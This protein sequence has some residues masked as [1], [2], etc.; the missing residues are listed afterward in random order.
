M[1]ERL[2]LLLLILGL[3]FVT[4]LS[5]G[6]AERHVLFIDG[7]HIGSIFTHTIDMKSALW[8]R[9]YIIHTLRCPTKAE[10]TAKISELGAISQDPTQ[11][12]WEHFVFCFT[13]HG[14]R[15][16][17]F[18][19]DELHGESGWG[20]NFSTRDYSHQVFNEIQVDAY[21]FIF[22]MCY[23]EA[24]VNRVRQGAEL[25]QKDPVGWVIFS[26]EKNKYSYTGRFPAGFFHACSPPS[27]NIEWADF[28]NDMV[29]VCWDLTPRWW[30]QKPGAWEIKLSQPGG[31]PILL[32]K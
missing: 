22:V 31:I 11:P 23:A 9:G 2:K 1:K 29:F 32:S 19:P 26:S 5:F 28:V 10:L 16:G 8:Q 17:T 27:K 3:S 15:N 4:I 24:A 7:H 30:A 12:S 13:G 18:S 21:T 25:S 6:Q 20:E 14:S